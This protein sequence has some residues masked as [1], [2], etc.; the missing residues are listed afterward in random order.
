MTARPGTLTA[1]TILLLLLS[2][3]NFPWPWMV[4]FPGAEEAPDWV[5]YSGIVLAL[6]GLICTYGLWQRARWSYWPS[7]V[8]SVLN[9]IVAAP[10]LTEAP[11]TAIKIAL[12]VTIVVAVVIIVLLLRRESKESFTSAGGAT[13]S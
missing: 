9:I 1:A 6:V 11:S 5:I 8:V 13:A 2:L 10:G 3:S 12:V 4:I 7:I